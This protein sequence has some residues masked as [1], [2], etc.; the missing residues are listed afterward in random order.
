MQAQST[1]LLQDQAREAEKARS[2]LASEVEA[3]IAT[4]HKMAQDQEN[5]LKHLKDASAKSLM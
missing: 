5:Q 4:G 3:Q 1:K 2:K